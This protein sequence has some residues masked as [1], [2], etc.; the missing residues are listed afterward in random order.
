MGAEIH[1]PLSSCI[2][3]DLT[4]IISTLVDEY[5]QISSGMHQSLI[6]QIH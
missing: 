5:G 2:L 1:V 6:K 4:I 3:Q